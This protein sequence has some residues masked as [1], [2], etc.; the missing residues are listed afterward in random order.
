MLVSIILITSQAS[1]YIREVKIP[2]IVFAY[3]GLGGQHTRDCQLLHMKHQGASKT[4]LKP[5][6]QPVIPLLNEEWAEVVAK[7]W[8]LICSTPQ[9]CARESCTATRVGR[10]SACPGILASACVIPQ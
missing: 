6:D 1:K 4:A 9:V 10:L 5:L 8:C 3:E 7:G 2:S